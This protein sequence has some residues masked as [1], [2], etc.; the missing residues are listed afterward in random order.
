[1][2]HNENGTK[3]TRF[4]F[5]LTLFFTLLITLGVIFSYVKSF[6]PDI[7]PVSFLP[8]AIISAAVFSF[9]FHL[10]KRGLIFLLSLLILVI[11]VII[12]WKSLYQSAGRT[13]LPL[14]ASYMKDPG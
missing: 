14:Y 5:L 1:M 12:T 7:E 3:E 6:L 13:F 11:F 9:L 4:S 10:K 2:S 8:A